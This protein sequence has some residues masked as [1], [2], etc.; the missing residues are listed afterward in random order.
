MPAPP[1]P[2]WQAR[3]LFT[4]GT[5][6]DPDVFALVSDGLSLEQVRKAD[7][8]VDGLQI[9][10]V[11]D[12]LY[13]VARQ[14]PGATAAG[15]VFFDLPARVL[16]RLA[17]FEFPEFVPDAISVATD[18][19]PVAC[20]YF[21]PVKTPP[22]SDLPWSVETW[23]AARKAVWLAQAGLA[24]SFYGVCAVEELE[25]HWDAILAHMEGRDAP[26]LPPRIAARCREIRE[27]EV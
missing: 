22:A 15:A 8:R 24:M 6:R 19:G 4:Y 3:P 2:A 18:E 20:S 21:K 23:P 27:A 26:A 13:P 17:W 1:Q 9:C 12:Q 14:R 25:R 7:A 10:G 16:D 5:L 11:L